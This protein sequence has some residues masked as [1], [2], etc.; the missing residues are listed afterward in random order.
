MRCK[1]NGSATQCDVPANALVRQ[2][3]T[4]SAADG[5]VVLDGRSYQANFSETRI[6]VTI[7]IPPSQG[8]FLPRFELVYRR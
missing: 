7:A 5:I 8:F 2:T 4:Y 3:G 6:T 1:P